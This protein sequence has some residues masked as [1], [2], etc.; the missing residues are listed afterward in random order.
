MEGDDGLP[1]FPDAQSPRADPLREGDPWAN[2]SA[3]PVDGFPTPNT[4]QCAGGHG[5]WA[6][7]AEPRP[8]TVFAE[9]MQLAASSRLR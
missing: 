1:I 5:P 6:G 9:Q 8:A 2:P 4:Q 7:R 3:T